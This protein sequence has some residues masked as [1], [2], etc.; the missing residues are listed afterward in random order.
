VTTLTKAPLVEVATQ[1][2]WGPLEEGTDGEFTFDFPQEE[3]NHSREALD[4][5]LR[6]NGFPVVVPFAPELE[7]VP[8]AYSRQYRR[9]E[10]EWPIIQTGLGVAGV[11]LNNEGYGWA[12]YK[13]EVINGFALIDRALRTRYP[14]GVPYF[15]FELLYLDGFPLSDKETPISFLQKKFSARLAPPRAFVDAPFLEPW[16]NVSA[17]G[18]SFE[19]RLA[20]PRGLLSVELEYDPMLLGRPGFAMDTRVRSVGEDVEY[21]LSGVD[22]WMDLAHNVQRHAFETLI[23]QGYRETFK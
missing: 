5:A 7:D 14:G 10:E 17:A 13:Q 8:F 16:P 6:E 9:A 19:L 11:H 23:T 18:L 21:T 12:S 15:G 22:A 20:E 2:R 1:F 3:Q 4:A